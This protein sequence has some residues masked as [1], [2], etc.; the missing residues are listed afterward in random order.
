MFI[1]HVTLYGRKSSIEI[2]LYCKIIC[3]QRH[4]AFQQVLSKST[5]TAMTVNYLQKITEPSGYLS[6]LSLLH[7]FISLAVSLHHSKEAPDWVYLK[8]LEQRWEEGFK[9]ASFL[10]ASVSFFKFFKIRAFSLFPSHITFYASGL[11]MTLTPAVL[12]L[13][14]RCL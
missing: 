6:N 4:L 13:L 14:V 5:M 8:W 3:F 12:K 9:W 11:P 7:Q 10:Y 2:T 1:L